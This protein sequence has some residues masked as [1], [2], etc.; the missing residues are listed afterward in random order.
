VHLRGGMGR[1][2]DI[3]REKREKWKEE[4]SFRWVNATHCS[5]RP[6]GRRRMV[7]GHFQGVNESTWCRFVSMEDEVS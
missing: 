4:R 1:N 6:A 7:R 3:G 2:V 5:Y